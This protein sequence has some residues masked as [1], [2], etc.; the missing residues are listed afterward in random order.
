MRLRQLLM[1]SNANIATRKPGM[2]M[3][4]EYW[5]IISNII[6]SCL[7]RVDALHWVL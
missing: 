1:G 7:A 6:T 3:T 2:T 5:L 4:A